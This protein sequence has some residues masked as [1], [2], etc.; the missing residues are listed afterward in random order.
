MPKSRDLNIDDDPMS[1]IMDTRRPKLQSETGW[2][3][4]GITSG[5]E[6]ISDDGYF[7]GVSF[8]NSWEN[9]TDEAPA[10]WWL[11]ESG[12]AR[13]RGRVTGGS[14]GTTIFTLPE[15]V[16]PKFVQEFICV[17]DDDGNLDL[18]NVRFRAFEEGD[19]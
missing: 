16:R 12:E 8:E 13:L 19:A 14:E 18:S 6:G 10:S 9:V 17:L 5:F 3:R 15:E 2:G 7:V 4:V 1:L 11:S